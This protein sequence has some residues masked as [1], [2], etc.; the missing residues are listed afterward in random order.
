MGCADWDFEAANEVE[1]NYVCKRL[2]PTE[3][4]L[5]RDGTH[6]CSLGGKAVELECRLIL[7]SVRSGLG[8]GFCVANLGFFN[9]Q[10]RLLG[11]CC[12]LLVPISDAGYGPVVNVMDDDKDDGPL[13]DQQIGEDWR[14]VPGCF[15]SVRLPRFNTDCRICYTG[16]IIYCWAIWK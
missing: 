1:S 14:T 2:A 4:D 16:D 7:E 6:T 13:T 5:S 9:W 3:I 15:S 12:Y 10:S 11:G 8:S